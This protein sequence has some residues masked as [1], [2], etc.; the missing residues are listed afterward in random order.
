VDYWG[1]C[2]INPL[3]KE[4]NIQ[5]Y[6]DLPNFSLGEDIQ[7]TCE[8]GIFAPVELSPDNT[9]LPNYTWS[10]GAQTPRITVTEQ[11]L[12]TLTVRN[13]CS[14]HSDTIIVKGCKAGVFIPN[15]FTPNEDGLND[16]FI[17]Y[18][19]GGVEQI[20]RMQIYDHLGGLVFEQ[21]DFAPNDPTQGWDG[22]FRGQKVQSG[23]YVYQILVRYTNTKTELFSGD[24]QVLRD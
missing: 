21:K 11:G 13:E 15:A 24:I 18:G 1:K 8:N 2:S 9:F 12:Y 22:K 10:T 4:F 19:N 20:E 23:N 5:T 7:N 6:P 3:R 14:T 16:H 17:L